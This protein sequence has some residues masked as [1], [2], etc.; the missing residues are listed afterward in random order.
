VA[1]DDGAAASQSSVSVAPAAA[2][3]AAS[4]S[5]SNGDKLSALLSALTDAHRAMISSAPSPAAV[6]P[7]PGAASSVAAWL[8]MHPALELLVLTIE[9][10]GFEG[11][12]ERLFLVITSHAHSH[13]TCLLPLSAMMLTEPRFFRLRSARSRSRPPQPAAAQPAQ[14]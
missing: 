10:E 14:R 12:K 6:G 13:L 3:T 9:G 1:K 5:S 8:A 11:N 2:G 7:A 4:T